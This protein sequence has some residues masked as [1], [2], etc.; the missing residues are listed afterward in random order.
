MSAITITNLQILI[1]AKSHQLKK[2]QRHLST[3]VI[4]LPL[5]VQSKNSVKISFNER[6]FSRKIKRGKSRDGSFS[7]FFKRSF[8]YENDVEKNKN[9]TIMNDNPSLMIVTDDPSLKIVN[10]ERRRKETD[11]KG[12]STYH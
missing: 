2:Q 7:F 4:C 6:E 12:I 9:E 10:E 11:L 8:R 1:L 3:T 5:W